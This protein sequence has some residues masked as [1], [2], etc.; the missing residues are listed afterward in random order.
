ML[1]LRSLPVNT[2]AALALA[3]LA[4]YSFRPAA[5][6]GTGTPVATS[7]DAG[8]PYSLT[9]TA[10][11]TGAGSSV[12]FFVQP[13]DAGRCVIRPVLSPAP[14]PEE[15]LA[16][17]RHHATALEQLR[18]QLED[19]RPTKV[20]VAPPVATLEPR[21]SDGTA[22]PAGGR[23]PQV[24]ARVARKWLTAGGIAAFELAPVAGELPS[25][26]RAP[27]STCTCRTA[28]YGSTR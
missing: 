20:A 9:V 1:V 25:S 6:L 21:H 5:A 13:A 26:S 11:T 7:S 28:S 19:S 18:A 14:A 8:S 12:V 4:G 27:M 16:V 24:R 23:R 10:T 2:P 22:G 15:R 17:L 3:G